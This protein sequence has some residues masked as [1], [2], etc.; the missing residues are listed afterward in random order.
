MKSASVIQYNIP[1]VSLFIY[2]HKE[3]YFLCGCKWHFPE[4][5]SF[6]CMHLLDI[7]VTR[8]VLRVRG[9]CQECTGVSLL[10]HFIIGI[11]SDHFCNL[12]KPTVWQAHPLHAVIS[13]VCKGVRVSRV[14]T[15][16]YKIF[17]LI[18]HTTMSVTFN[19]YSRVQHHEC[20]WGG[21]VWKCAPLS[22]LIQCIAS[23]PLRWQVFPPD[24]LAIPNLIAYFSSIHAS[25]FPLLIVI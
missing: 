5:H 10:D 7:W 8:H 21:T 13:Q 19:V 11:V 12:T 23:R 9:E 16:L 4:A 3:L 25:I 22:P 20:L 24:Y 15:S 6:P 2:H 17:C 18:L 1:V 14:L